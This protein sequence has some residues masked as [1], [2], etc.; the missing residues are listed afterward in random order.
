MKRSLIISFLS[1]FILNAVF[2]QETDSLILQNPVHVSAS[3]HNLKGDP[4]S[5][6]L[7]FIEEANKEEVTKAWDSAMEKGTKSKMEKDGNKRFIHKIIIE[8]IDK[9]TLFDVHAEVIEARKGIKVFVAFQAAD[10]TWIDPKKESGNTIRAEKVLMKFGQKIYGEVLSDKLKVEQGVLKD[11]EKQRE[12]IAKDQT[13]LTKSIQADSLGIHNARNEIKLKKDEYSTVTE[14]LSDQRTGMV[15][16]NYSS[17]DQKKEAE[18][19]IKETE[20]DQKKITKTI[21][22]LRNDIIDMEKNI[23]ESFYEIEQLKVDDN[24]IMQKITVQNERI[25]TLENAIFDLQN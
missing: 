20:K 18:K 15:Q 6:F 21:E 14:K 7:L 5:V 17:D 19:L 10:S 22:N 25:K 12:D 1:F 16:T 4:Q 23:S 8:D 2:S 9:E 13:N 3:N 24:D 11:F